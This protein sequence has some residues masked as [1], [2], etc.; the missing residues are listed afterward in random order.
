VTTAEATLF[1]QGGLFQP[2]CLEDWTPEV[3][4]EVLADTMRQWQAEDYLSQIRWCWNPRLRTTI[5]RAVF[6]DHLVELNPHLLAR[7]PGEVRGVL[8]HELAHLVVVRRHGFR[9]TAHGPRWKSLMSAAGES[10]RATHQLDVGN[11]RRKRSSRARLPRRGQAQTLAR[12]EA[13]W[14]RVSRRGW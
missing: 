11:L 5:G 14:R 6:E 8:V 10:T 13:W 9:E 3:I 2:E 4:T 1:Q 7:H 12:L